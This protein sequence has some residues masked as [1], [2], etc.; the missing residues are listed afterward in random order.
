MM[1]T[2]GCPGCGKKMVIK[3]LHCAQCDITVTGT[4]YS[5]TFGYLDKDSLDFVENF[6]LTRGNMKEMEE[7]LGVSYPTVKSRLDKIIKDLQDIKRNEE[8]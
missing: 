6:I 5:H 3:T 7:I 8:N 1:K 4:F 2:I